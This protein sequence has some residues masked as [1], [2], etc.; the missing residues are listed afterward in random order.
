[1]GCRLTGVKYDNSAGV[2]VELTYT[3]VLP[4]YITLWAGA[5]YFFRTNP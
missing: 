1:M 5:K 4:G 3:A 2:R